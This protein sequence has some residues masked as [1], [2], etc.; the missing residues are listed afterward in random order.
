MGFSSKK[1]LKSRQGLK[2]CDS[3]GIGYFFNN[4]GTINNNGTTT[5][6][7]I[8]S[9]LNFLKNTDTIN[10]YF[11]IHSNNN[12]INIIDTTN[13]LSKKIKQHNM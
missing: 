13:L 8:K 7:K 6:N 2:N 9:E 11:H 4:S 10:N 3:F 1:G 5:L 12:P